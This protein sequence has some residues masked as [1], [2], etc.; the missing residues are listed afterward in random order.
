[1]FETTV[2]HKQ[3]VIDARMRLLKD[4]DSVTIIV[5]ESRKASYDTVIEFTVGFDDDVVQTAVDNA[6]DAWLSWAKSQK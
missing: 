1:M 6:A 5:D 2:R 3:S 4:G